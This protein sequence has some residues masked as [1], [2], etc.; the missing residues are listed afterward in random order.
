MNSVIKDIDNRIKRHLGGIRLAFRGI[1]TLVKAAGQIQ[2][3]QLNGVAGEQLQGAEQFQEY[4]LTTN[5]PPGGMAIVLPIGG[6]TAHGIIIATEHGSYRFKNLKSGEVAL[7]TDEGDHIYL[8]RGRIMDILTHT[9][10]ITA[11]TAV[12]IDTP[13]VNCSN[14]LVAVNDIY[15]HNN[16]SMLGMRTVF[17]T[18]RHPETGGTTN[19]PNTGM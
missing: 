8:K 9:L 6:K 4:G 7:Y 17:N 11:T 19:I 5:M 2:L 3:V 10:N 12:N 13:V 14:D 18:H 16:K 1:V 15:D